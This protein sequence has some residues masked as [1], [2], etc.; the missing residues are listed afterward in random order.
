[1]TKRNEYKRTYNRGQGIIWKRIKIEKEKEG[2]KQK[3]TK[4]LSD[5]EEEIWA[6]VH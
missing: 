4:E 1:M 3:E 6:Y 2:V 5:Q